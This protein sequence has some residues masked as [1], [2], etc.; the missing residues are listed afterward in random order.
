MRKP[1]PLTPAEV[2]AHR[3]K[4]YANME[5]EAAATGRRRVFLRCAE[6]AVRKAEQGAGLKYAKESEIDDEILMTLEKVIK[7]WTDLRDEIL[8]RLTEGRSPNA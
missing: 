7:A 3:A 4:A 1:K 8:N 6:N 5:D 2:A